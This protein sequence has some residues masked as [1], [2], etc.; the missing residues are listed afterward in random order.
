MAKKKA[1]Q[2]QTI[3]AARRLW[4]RAATSSRKGNPKMARS[5]RRAGNAVNKV[6]EAGNTLNR[7][8]KSK[9]P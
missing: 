2:R 6:Y 3:K 4:K 9:L 8:S 1:S 5:Q 7:A